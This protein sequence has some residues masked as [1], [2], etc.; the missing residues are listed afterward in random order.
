MSLICE[1]NHIVEK[2]P[3]RSPAEDD[4][5]QLYQSPQTVLK[6]KLVNH[7]NLSLDICI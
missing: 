7:T 5:I 6:F 1:L 2:S 4:L 3:F